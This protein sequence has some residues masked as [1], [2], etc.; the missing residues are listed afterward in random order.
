[1]SITLRP[2][3]SDDCAR[4]AEIYAPAVTHGSSSFELVPP[5]ADEMA[6]RMR[7]LTDGGF[8]YFAAMR[9][10]AVVGYAYAGLYRTRPAYRFTVENSVYVAPEAQRMGIGRVLLDALIETCTARGYRQMLAVIGD[11]VSQPGSVGLHRA[12]GFVEVGRLPDVGFKFGRWC[13]TL[14]MQR[15]LGE[16]SGSSPT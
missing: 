11:S 8:P 14:L 15:A 16:G 1:M 13:D 9:D 3:T 5:D 4:I 2:A 12:C 10:G 6:R 7:A